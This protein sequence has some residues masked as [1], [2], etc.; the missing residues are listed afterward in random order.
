LESAGDALRLVI[1]D[2]G[3]GFTPRSLRGNGGLGLESIGE[4]TRLIQGQVSIRSR[5]HR[6]TVITVDV[7]LKRR[8]K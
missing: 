1:Q 4:R 6:G 3:V 7:P 8:E 5:P 2:F